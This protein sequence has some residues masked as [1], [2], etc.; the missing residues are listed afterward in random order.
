MLTR[1]SEAVGA[2]GVLLACA[3]VAALGSPPAAAHAAP[4]PA[5]H[6]HTASGRAGSAP[7]LAT[8]PAGLVEATWADL[9]LL[10]DGAVVG[11]GGGVVAIPT[12]GSAVVAP[13]LRQAQSAWIA[14]GTVPGP[15]ER[16]DLAVQALRDLDALVLADGSAIAAASPG[17]DLVWP[18]DASFVAAALARTGHPGDALA[19]LER[20]AALHAASADGVFEARY[21]PSDGSVPDGRA[22][23]L[24]GC[25]WALWAV[26]HW[27]Q[28]APGDP[29]GLAT[30]EPMVRGCL[31]AIDREVSPVTGLPGPWPDYW[32]VAETVPTLGT[33]AAL[34]AGA[35]MGAGALMSQ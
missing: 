29:A 5:A 12:G 11:P 21:V 28:A 6:G 26:A 17:W 24:D 13:A 16:S 27:R 8:R 10:A 2:W 35:L 3:A 4:V 30:L 23:Q 22:R 31:D 1:A 15:T 19:V 33:V 9:P 34:L 14:N 25:G 7:A 20:L 32:E 18:R